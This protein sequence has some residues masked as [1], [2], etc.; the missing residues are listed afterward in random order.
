MK[1]VTSVTIFSDAVGMRISIT[2]SEID[3]QGKIIKD[4][5]RID[6]V[7]TNKD[8]KATASAL[9]EYAQELVDAE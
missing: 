4:N 8:A 5:I 2:Y 3:E 6:R 1:I 7:I 9:M